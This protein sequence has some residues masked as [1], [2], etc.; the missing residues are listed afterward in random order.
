MNELTYVGTVD[1][2]KW[3]VTI[4]KYNDRRYCP[5]N[6]IIKALSQRGIEATV[7]RY[8]LKKFVKRM[9]VKT[10]VGGTQPTIMISLFGAVTFLNSK[11]L[12]NVHKEE[13]RKFFETY[14]M[15]ETYFDDKHEKVATKRY[16]VAAENNRMFN[17]SEFPLVFDC[18]NKLA[19][20]NHVSVKKEISL[21]LL[22][23]IVSE[24]QANST[25]FNAATKRRLMREVQSR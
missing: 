1:N 9:N 19:R 21:L 14:A 2:A 11:K 25:M 5:M 16:G 7:E 23:A 12:V 15:D 3:K 18:V 20:H 10:V 24:L 22:S 6:E 17:L 8:N 13:Y 4:Y